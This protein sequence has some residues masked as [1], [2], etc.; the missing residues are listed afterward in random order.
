[1]ISAISDSGNIRS[2]SVYRPG[3]VEKQSL[4]G[5]GTV[6]GCRV[7]TGLPYACLTVSPPAVGAR[8]EFRQ[9]V[10]L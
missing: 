3:L 5:V 6:T 9:N 10:V 7:V 2:L 4:G 8:Y 1:M